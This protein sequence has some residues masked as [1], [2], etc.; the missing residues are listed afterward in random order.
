MAQQS[1]AGEGHTGPSPWVDQSNAHRPAMHTYAGTPHFSSGG[2]A[3]AASPGVSARQSLFEHSDL[4]QLTGASLRLES[5]RNDSVD[6]FGGHMARSSAGYS[7]SSVRP[8]DGFGA[9]ASPGGRQNTMEGGVGG[10]SWGTGEEGSFGV[11]QAGASATVASSGLRQY[12]VS[13]GGLGAPA[14]ASL[15][16]GGGG[17]SGSDL[18]QAGYSLLSMSWDSVGAGRGGHKRQPGGT[19]GLNTT[20]INPPPAPTQASTQ[21]SQQEAP[22]ALQAAA[23]GIANAIGRSDTLRV[24]S[25]RQGSGTGE[26]GMFSETSGYVEAGAGSDAKRQRCGT[27]NGTPQAD[28][29]R[30]PSAATVEV[31]GS[32]SVRRPVPTVQPGTQMHSM[33]A[34]ALSA[35]LGNDDDVEA[36]G[37]GIGPADGGGWG[38][39]HAPPPMHASAP[40]HLP[41]TDEILRQMAPAGFAQVSFTPLQDA[42]SK[43]MPASSVGGGPPAYTGG[44][45]QRHSSQ[46]PHHDDG[47]GSVSDSVS[48]RSGSQSAGVAGRGGAG[49]GR[50]RATAGSR[51]LPTSAV[52]VLKE[53]MLAPANYDHPWPTEEE[54]QQLADKCG[55]SVRQVTVWLTNGRKRVWKP[56][57]EAQ[58]LPVTDYKQARSAKKRAELHHITSTS[59]TDSSAARGGE[60]PQGGTK[61]PRNEGGAQQQQGGGHGNPTSGG[62]GIGV[63]GK[64]VQGAVA[65]ME[66]QQLIALHSSL[67]GMLGQLQHAVHQ[68]Q[69]ADA[70]K[71][72]QSA[73]LAEAARA[74]LSQTND[75]M[76]DSRARQL[77]TLLASGQ[78]QYQ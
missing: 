33:D 64:G 41:G 59:H 32:S 50:S 34:A 44:A 24:S 23:A 36:G 45:P 46:G 68:L 9:L 76:C 49:G 57:R 47:G 28:S 13:A 8:A 16:Q 35:M 11:S 73:Q 54:K 10:A 70:L 3:N 7:A 31:A 2:A 61:R 17:A 12:S 37:V 77:L 19:D 74:V 20:A 1:A 29:G 43:G 14:P 25:W 52:R 6:A 62:G 75:S 18:K 48:S 26:S 30:N 55:I 22:N 66:R 27:E 5:L 56:L 67:A 60:A 38:A 21:Q 78:R 39:T 63:G 15:Q 4:R 65:S 58:G 71:H 42:T 72:Q 51:A 69:S 40:P 53:W